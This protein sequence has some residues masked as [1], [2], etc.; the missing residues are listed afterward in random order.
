LVEQPVPV[1]PAYS[2]ASLRPG[3]C[4]AVGIVVVVLLV[5]LVEVGSTQGQ[6][7]ATDSPVVRI[8]QRNASL[9]VA[10]RLPLGAQMH[11]GLQVTRPTTLRKMNRQSLAT[12]SGPLLNG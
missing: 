3:H 12:G 11:S 1:T 8:R 4:A 7:S 2:T 10:G 5:E 6:L 9:A